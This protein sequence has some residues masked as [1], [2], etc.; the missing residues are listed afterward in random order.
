M[1]R[2]LLTGSWYALARPPLLVPAALA[3]VLPVMAYRA[4]N[5]GYATQV[6]LGVAVI[7]ACALAA[8][9]DDPA[10]EVAAA[11]PHP[12]ATRCA[13][14]LLVGLALALPIAVFALVIADHQAVEIR[15]AGTALQMAA[16]VAVGPA[17][18]FGV[19][20]W[21]DVNQATHV[22]TVAVLSV[23]LGLWAIPH[24]LAVVSIQPW[25]PPWEAVLIRWGALVLLALA[26]I[27][28]AWRDPLAR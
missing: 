13:A 21:S 9:A 12:R 20:A 24:T 22:A 16:F 5:D 11:S 3:A 8:T 15:L 14:R 26:T 19:W 10:H 2:T 27:A 23:C 4:L 7:L 25:G 17:V 6:V 28:A 18:G 1:S